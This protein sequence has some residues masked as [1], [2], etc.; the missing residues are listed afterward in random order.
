MQSANSS[1]CRGCQGASLLPA[2][3]GAF[4]TCP[5]CISAAVAGTV[6]G[7][8]SALAAWVFYAQAGVLLAAVVLACG[9][10]LLLGLHVAAYARR[11]A[12]SA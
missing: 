4:G 9:F 8:S 5:H 3:R 1:G 10:S 2:D 11:K 7:W 6:I 12:G